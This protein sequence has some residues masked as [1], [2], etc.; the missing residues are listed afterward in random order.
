[1]YYLFLA[2]SRSLALSLENGSATS[3]FAFV[4]I[5][6]ICLICFGACYFCRLELPEFTGAI[7]TYLLV[8]VTD[9]LS[10]SVLCALTL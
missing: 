4:L 7:V 8:L 5:C 2:L 9:A 10:C 3:D 6:L 1:V